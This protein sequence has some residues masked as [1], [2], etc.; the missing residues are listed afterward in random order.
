MRHGRSLSM[1]AFCLLLGPGAARADEAL[2]LEDAVKMALG[3]NERALKAPLRVEAAEGQLDRARSA[4]LPTL[5]AGSGALFSSTLDR[6][7]RAVTGSGTLSLNQPLL[8]PSAFPLYAQARHQLE[9]ERWGA[10]QDRRLVAFDTA[11]AFLVVLTTEHL[12][13]AAHR[14]L[15]RAS[16]T[17][18]NIEA[19]AGSQLASSNDVTR[20]MIENTAARR[21]VV[22]AE[23]NVARAYLQLGF[24]VGK[25]VKGPLAP[26]DRTT[27]A[28]ELGGVHTDDDV[29]AAQARRPD[30]RSAEER[31]QALRESAKEPLYRLAP[32]LAAQAQIKLNP[33]PISPDSGHDE[34]VQLTLSWNIYDA[35][36]RYADRRTR[37]AQAESQALDEKQLR[38]SIATDVAL[39]TAALKAAREVYK[40]SDEAAVIAQRNTAETEVLYDHGLAHA[41][42]VV[43]AT[44]SRYDAEVSRE[45][46]RLSMEQAYLDLRFALGLGPID[47]ASAG[48]APPKG[49]TP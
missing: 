13:D 39:A 14:R 32:T 22:Q 11:H 3:S 44:A 48:A 41:I 25:E 16:L 4:F 12:L 47:E 19:R 2:G 7:G 10:T 31:T 37:L 43:D 8:N 46:A 5:T 30:V 9:S 27:H 1:L 29:R 24:L 40:L 45:T 21:E 20:S 35:G 33:A 15:E 36:Q 49:A 18:K 38:R 26:P 34:T 17:L 6:A 23:G 42:E 28:A